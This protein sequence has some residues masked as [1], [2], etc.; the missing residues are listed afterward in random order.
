[1]ILEATPKRCLF[2]F[3]TT[4][5][6]VASVLIFC[7]GHNA[8]E[9]YYIVIGVCIGGNCNSFGLIV[10]FSLGVKLSIDNPASTGWNRIFRPLG[11]RTPTG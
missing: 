1:M 9:F 8:N 5:G 10:G 2:F 3:V 4:T 6:V 11:D 7:W